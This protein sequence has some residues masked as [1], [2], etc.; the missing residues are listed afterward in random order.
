MHIDPLAAGFS[1][2]QE[3][4]VLALLLG[5]LSELMK[6]QGG[7]TF[8]INALK[9]MLRRLS[10]AKSTGYELTIGLLAAMTNLFM[11]NNTVAII[12]S[13]ETAKL[14]AQQGNIK[15]ERSASMLDIFACIVQGLLPYGGQLL[16]V[17]ASFSLS[18]VAIIAE[19]YYCYVLAI[20]AIIALAIRAA[21]AAPAAP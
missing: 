6:Q 2:M 5:G 10:M 9:G 8:I 15:A 21:R 16:L 12:V 19:V 17:A 14:L 3:L 11:A 18:P 4:I 1:Q 13:G 7:L 20:V